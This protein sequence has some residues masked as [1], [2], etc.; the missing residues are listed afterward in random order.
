MAA[1]AQDPL[2]VVDGCHGYD[3]SGVRG[4]STEAAVRNIV[5]LLLWDNTVGQT[6]LSRLPPAT[7]IELWTGFFL[8]GG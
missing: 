7:S 1:T 2:P 6:D 5:V 4:N 8:L 3:R